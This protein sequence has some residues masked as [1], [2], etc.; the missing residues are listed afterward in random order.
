MPT[1]SPDGTKVLFRQT[2]DPKTPDEWAA[3]VPLDGGV[4]KTL[5]LPVPAEEVEGFRWAPDGK[6][7]L[8]DRNENGVGNI[9]SA[10]LVGGGVRKITSFDSDRIFAF[11]VS[12]DNRLLMSR[13]TAVR[14]VVLIKKR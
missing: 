7:I 1:I 11:D 4:T 12:P 6:A 2:P 8:Y 13:G 14:D 5:K 9:W 10:S 3:I